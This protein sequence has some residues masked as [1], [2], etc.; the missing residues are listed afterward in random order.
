MHEAE[1]SGGRGNERLSRGEHKCP[2]EALQLNRRELNL[3]VAGQGQRWL[4]QTLRTDIHRSKDELARE[5]LL[6]AEKRVPVVNE[7]GVPAE[8]VIEVLAPIRRRRDQHQV[9]FLLF[10]HV[11]QSAL[12]MRTYP[13]NNIASPRTAG[14]VGDDGKVLLPQLLARIFNV[15]AAAVAGAAVMVMV[16]IGMMGWAQPAMA[17]GRGGGLE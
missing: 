4:T 13:S 8:V 12:L 3:H 17:R 1:Y 5:M 11:Q 10:S 9:M 6:P 14:H 15:A 2:Q 7:V 16:C